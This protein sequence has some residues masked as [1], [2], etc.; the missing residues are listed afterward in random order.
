MISMAQIAPQSKYI[1]VPAL[2]ER[3]DISK[4]YLEQVFSLLRRSGLVTSIKGAQGG[5]QL[6]RD[7]SEIT[8]YD[9]LAATETALFENVEQTVPNSAPGIERAMQE[10]LFEAVNTQLALALQ[11]ISL[12]ELA[13]EAHKNTGGD[14]YM[15]YL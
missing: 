14:G 15:Y 7:A 10:M 6:A 1:T 11:R 12:S 9:I 13:E 4:I 3:L 2:S 8:A 5:Y